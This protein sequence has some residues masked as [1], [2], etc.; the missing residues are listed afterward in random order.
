MVATTFWCLEFYEI[1]EQYIPSLKIT[2]IPGSIMSGVAGLFFTYLRIR[3][4]HEF[5]YFGLALVFLGGVLFMIA[6]FPIPNKFPKPDHVREGADFFGVDLENYAITILAFCVLV[7]IAYGA[8]AGMELFTNSI[9]VLDRPNQDAYL[10]EE[11]VRILKHDYPEK[12][13]VSHLHIQLALT[14]QMITMIGYKISEIKGKIYH[15]MLMTV[16]TGVLTISYGAWVLNHYLIWVGAGILILSTIALCVYGFMEISKKELGEK[17]AE[18]S[19]GERLKAMMAD[20]VRVA[21]YWIFLYAQIVVTICGIIV[22]LQTRYT[23]RMHEYTDVEYD[24]NVGHWH[25]LA[26]LL[27]TLV[28]LIAMDHF[29]REDTRLKV[30]GGWFIGVGGTWAFTFANAYMMRSPTVDKMPTMILTFVGVWILI[31]GFIMGIVVLLKARKK[32]LQ[33]LKGDDL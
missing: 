5:F 6:T 19:R 9:W 21:L 13:I 8:L 17:Y 3:W 29:Q 10:A 12:F 30:I 33:L 16:P 2:L 7:S 26:V 31:M 27:A 1:R 11:G 28:L 24:F 14:A 18:A 22:G 4:L 15:Y 23:F 32:Q 20:P 25:L